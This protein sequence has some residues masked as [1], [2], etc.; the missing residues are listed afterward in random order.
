[1]ESLKLLWLSP[2]HHADIELARNLGRAHS[3]EH[4]VVSVMGISMV[5]QLLLMTWLLLQ[6]H[7]EIECTNHEHVPR[8]TSHTM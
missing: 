1:M 4:F 5:V 2:A 7:S 6:F 3:D 8:P